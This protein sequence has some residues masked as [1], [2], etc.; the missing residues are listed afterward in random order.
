MPMLL[1]KALSLTASSLLG[2]DRAPARTSFEVYLMILSTCVAVHLRIRL[3]CC[4][5]PLPLLTRR[6]AFYAVTL[7]AS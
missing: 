1:S 5:L 2:L 3:Q 4:S 7:H 6:H